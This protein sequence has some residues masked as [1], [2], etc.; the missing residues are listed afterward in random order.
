MLAII[1]GTSQFL[2]NWSNGVMLCA[3]VI[4]LVT[5]AGAEESAPVSPAEFTRSPLLTNLFADDHVADEWEA[6]ILQLQHRVAAADPPR[7]NYYVEPRSVGTRR[8]TEPPRYVRELSESGLPLFKDVD[9][10]DFNADYRV[11]YEYRDDDLRRSIAVTD[12][13]FLLRTRTYVGIKEILD[14]LRFVMEFEDARRYNSHFPLD[15]RDANLME[16][17]QAY[18]ELYFKDAIETDSPIRLQY[19]RMAMEYVDRRLIARN[20]WRNTTNNFQGFRAI[21]GEQS[22][23]WQLSLLALQPVKR[24]IYDPDVPNHNIWFYGAIADWRRWSDI[25]TFQPY[26][27]FLDQRGTASQVPMEIHTLAVRGYGIVGDTGYDYDV[28]VAFQFGRYDDGPHRAFGFTSEIGYTFETDWKPRLSAFLGYASGDRNPYDNSDQRF[29]R[30]FGFGRPWSAD[31]YFTWEN[32]IAPKVRLDFVPHKKLKVDMGY[33]VFW[34]ASATDSW[35]NAKRRDPT[36]QSGTFVGHELDV[37]FRWAA[38]DRVDMTFGYAHFFSGP[39]VKN[40]GRGQDTDF[41]YVEMLS[42]LIK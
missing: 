15:D 8:E 27:L 26:Y 14:P 35:S 3:W 19:G 29:N 25:V 16:F 21:L 12:N 31:D 20:E 11:R 42:R 17:M 36:G 22:N 23:E 9:G 10:I 32:L 38:N 5:S 13:P 18:A 41:F 30:L 40:T 37:R 39:F 33:G 7:K 2:V 28:D 34:L 24:L 1:R 6:E 4:L